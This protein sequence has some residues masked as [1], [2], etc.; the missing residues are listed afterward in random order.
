VDVVGSAA[1]PIADPDEP[2]PDGA[3][4]VYWIMA[5]GVT[6]TNAQDADLIWTEGDDPGPYV[7]E[8]ALAAAGYV[9]GS[10]GAGGNAAGLWIGTE[11]EYAGL[12]P[13]ATTVYIVTEDP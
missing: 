11:T 7:S 5:E 8:A 10:G 1:S 13:S 2:R 9:V 4:I 6:P 12:T 3:V